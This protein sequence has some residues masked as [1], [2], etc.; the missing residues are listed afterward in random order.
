MDDYREPTPPPSSDLRFLE[1]TPF[2]TKITPIRD[3]QENLARIAR[4]GVASGDPR[5]GGQLSSVLGLQM[6]TAAAGTASKYGGQ[7]IRR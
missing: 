4:Y 7:N 2:V 3:A 5:A 6:P 1:L